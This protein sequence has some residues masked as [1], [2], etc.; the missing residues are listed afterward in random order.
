MVLDQTKTAAMTQGT[1]VDY[2]NMANQS[3]NTAMTGAIGQGT[4]MN[5]AAANELEAYKAQEDANLG[6]GEVG[7]A[8]LGAGTK[9]ATGYVTPKAAT[10]GAIPG[11]G[12]LPGQMPSQGGQVP[13]SASPSGG[14]QVDD[15]NA[16]LTPG[17]FVLPVDVVKWKGEEFFQKLIDQARTKK[18]GASAK[19]E[20][21]AA[22]PGPTTFD[23]GGR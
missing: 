11:P 22:L 21:G 4:L 15:V 1:P 3:R 20:M 19:P 17:E 12:Q 14:Q 13:M 5:Q 7:M 9:I 2:G 8:L 16:R 6:W 18:D 23:S 10:G